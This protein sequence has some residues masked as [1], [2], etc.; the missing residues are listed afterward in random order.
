MHMHTRDEVLEGIL[1]NEELCDLYRS[2]CVVDAVQ[3]RV[4]WWAGHVAGES[5][6]I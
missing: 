6:G 3:S 2:P 1:H 5:K 4:V